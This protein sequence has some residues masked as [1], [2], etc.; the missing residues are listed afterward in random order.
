MKKAELVANVVSETCVSKK[1]VEA[2]LGGVFDNIFKAVK[3]DGKFQLIGIGT[4]SLRERAARKGINPKTKE[5]IDIKASK[6]IGFKPAAKV[7][8]SL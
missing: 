3:E 2:V 4:F 1:D 7:K 6:S 8:E 5:S